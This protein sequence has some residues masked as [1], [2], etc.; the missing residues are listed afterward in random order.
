MVSVLPLG[1]TLQVVTSTFLPLRQ[2]VS[3]IRLA[4]TLWSETLVTE[5]SPFIGYGL[6]SNP[7]V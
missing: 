3:T 5:G 6:P 2:S 7:A 1:D 4:E